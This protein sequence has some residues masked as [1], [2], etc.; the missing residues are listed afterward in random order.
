MSR[1]EVAIAILH[2]AESP[3]E[4]L[5][6]RLLLQLR[7][8]I[9]Q[10]VYPGHWA[11]FGG[12]LEP[13]ESADVAVQ[14]ELLEE[15]GYAPP[16]I[17]HFRSYTNDPQIIRHVYHA[18]LSVNLGALTLM[19]GWDMGWFSREDVQRGDRYSARAAQVRPLGKPHQQILLDF[20]EGDRHHG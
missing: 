18:V 5:H 16:D 11:L 12:H 1:P 20:L 2:Q 13:G 10:I 7:D 4:R 6:P 3:S 15:I 9:P 8:N 19:E 14:R 17:L